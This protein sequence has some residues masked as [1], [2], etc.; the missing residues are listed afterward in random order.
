MGIQWTLVAA[1]LYTEIAAVIL[2]MIPFISPKSWN[3]LFQSRFMKSLG[4]QA[5]N[6]FK[7]TMAGLV[8]LFFDS[9]R[10]MRRYSTDIGNTHVELQHSLMMFRAQ[11]NFYITGFSFLLWLIIRKLV[12]LIC[13][14]AVLLAANE[15]SMKQAQSATEAAQS[16]LK[17]SGESAKQIDKGN[18]KAEALEKELK[19]LKT[20]LEKAHEGVHH[21]I[22]DRDV[23]KE[24]AENLSK[25]YHL[26]F[27]EHEKV[28]QAVAASADTKKGI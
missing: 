6:Y 13:A 1:C 5:D 28:R 27:Y 18:V 23:L 16:L 20:L 15:A 9:V 17:M 2:L 11:R 24:H 4:A 14:Q 26:L 19:E 12:T 3:E 22:L 10:E 7:V 25:E 8:L 21:L